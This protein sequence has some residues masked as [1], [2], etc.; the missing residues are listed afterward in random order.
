MRLVDHRDAGESRRHLQ[1]VLL[2]RLLPNLFLDLAGN[3]FEVVGSHVGLLLALA[4][5]VQ[6]RSGHLSDRLP[7]HQKVTAAELS[8]RLIDRSVEQVVAG[9]PADLRLLRHR[10]ERSGLLRSK[11]FQKILR[12]FPRHVEHRKSKG[13][14]VKRHLSLP[15][16]YM[17]D[18]FGLVI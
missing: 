4:D 9:N 5:R 16:L 7:K 10:I 6:Q 12:E 17:L 1:N 11:Q 13:S 18:K 3:V 8:R 14:T 2:D 15:H